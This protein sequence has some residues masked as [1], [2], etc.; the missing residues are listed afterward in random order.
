MCEEAPRSRP[1][2]VS[3]ARAPVSSALVVQRLGTHLPLPTTG[4]VSS[5]QKPPHP[6]HSPVRPQ[7]QGPALAQSE[8]PQ[9]GMTSQ[10]VSGA[11]SDRDPPPTVCTDT[12]GGGGGRAAEPAAPRGAGL[13]WGCPPG[14]PMGSSPSDRPCPACSKTG[15][16]ARLHMAVRW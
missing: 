5:Q 15:A 10:E 7:P 9:M 4:P 6:W 2:A 11:I 1:M 13:L 12:R 8:S 14:C 3:E 16:G